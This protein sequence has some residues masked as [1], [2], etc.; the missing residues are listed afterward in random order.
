MAQAQ[1]DGGQRLGEPVVVVVARPVAPDDV[2][3]LGIQRN[4]LQRLDQ[5]SGIFLI[6]DEMARLGDTAAAAQ[7]QHKRCIERHVV[8][9]IEPDRARLLLARKVRTQAGVG[10]RVPERYVE[11]AIQRHAVFEVE[12][13]VRSLAN[14]QVGDVGWHRCDRG[15]DDRFRAMERCA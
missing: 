10:E 5:R 6:R 12:D 15:Y 4:R 8:Q 7:Q 2:V 13:L 3:V 11:L 1:I 9:A 14:G